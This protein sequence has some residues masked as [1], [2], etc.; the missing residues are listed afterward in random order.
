M[1][2]D[3]FGVGSVLVLEGACAIMSKRWIGDGPSDCVEMRKCG[4]DNKNE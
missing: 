4:I 1:G 3:S 2:G